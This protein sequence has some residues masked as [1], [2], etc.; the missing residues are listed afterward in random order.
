M[1]GREDRSENL[2]SYVRLEERVP[3]D[4]PLRPIR[5]LADE[6]RRREHTAINAQCACILSKPDRRHRA[7][8]E[9]AQ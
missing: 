6:V 9:Q 1:C 4:H 5:V 3:A 2:F 7:T 8:L